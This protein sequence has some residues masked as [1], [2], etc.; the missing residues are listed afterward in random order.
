MQDRT[1]LQALFRQPGTRL[2][3]EKEAQ[4]YLYDV[5][6]EALQNIGVDPSSILS[7]ELQPATGPVAL[8]SEASDAIKKE[9]Q[10][11]DRNLFRLYAKRVG[12]NVQSANAG[13][14][15]LKNLLD[16]LQGRVDAWSLE[17]G[18]EY[19]RGISPMFDSK[20]ARKYDSYWNWVIQDLYA[21]YSSV[22]SGQIEKL[23]AQTRDGHGHFSRR[24]TR[25]L[26]D[27]IQHLLGAVK[28]IT[29]MQIREVVERWL[30]D[31]QKACTDAS[32][33][34]Q[35]IFR[36]SVSSTVPVLE[37]SV[38]GIPSV[39]T[40][41]RLTRHLATTIPTT[42]L[43]AV[44]ET[45]SASPSSFPES[46]IHDAVFSLQP[47]IGNSPAES[48]PSD[49]Q[50][51]EAAYSR[52]AA[53]SLGWTPEVQTKSQSGWCRNDRITATYL[54]W[55]LQASSEGISLH[56]KSV[57]V[58]GAGRN[59]IGSEIVALCLS[60]GAMVLVTTSSYSKET[61]DYYQGL[62][63]SHGARD[64]QLVVVPW[65]GGSYQD[66]RSLVRYVYEELGWDPD[67][68]IPFAAM[69][70]AGRAIDEL[71]DRSELAHRIMLTNLLRLLGSIK[72][73]KAQRRIR[74]HPTHVILPLSPN[75]GSFGQDGTYAES[76][77]GLEAL[78]NKWWSEDWQEYLTLCGSVIGWT[79]GT[80]LMN[81]N[82]VLATGLEKD[83]GI[84]TFSSTEMAWHLVGLMDARLVSFCD[85]EPI[86]ADLS[87]GLTAS[88]N[89]K[90]VLKQIQHEINS[91]TDIQRALYRE[92]QE[93]EHERA[94]TVPI[95]VSKKARIRVESMNLPEWEEIQLLSREL[96]GMVDL[97][98]VVVVVGFGEAGKLCLISFKFFL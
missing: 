45:G 92:Q 37:I 53:I 22:S 32:S 85:T 15:G 2:S 1:L 68:V 29:H 6:H 59:S 63:R 79:R 24:V 61:V 23:E 44:S 49:P 80:G 96:E 87:G 70:E 5:A 71:D 69:G 83:V 51:T 39:T 81:S 66:V 11:R 50:S 58:T 91:R 41:P 72:A 54:S 46:S 20:K 7:R 31:L 33:Q 16:D 48:V 75:H 19:E 93:M 78:L 28:G 8:S 18:E 94:V 60:A 56:E 36:H 88:M 40:K 25:Q 9:Q 55:F 74:T 13:D 52:L 42:F 4:S 43:D 77:L 86:K 26:L 35:P 30:L 82:D 17:H 21:T 27:A 62:Y 90:S 12:H 73:E 10:E 3:S 95:M 14:M 76:K 64:S 38:E 84:R 67:H 34:K 57:L 98:R 47:T 89:L 97:N 65:N